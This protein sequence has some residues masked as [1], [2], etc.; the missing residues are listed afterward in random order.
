MQPSE[1]AELREIVISSCR[2]VLPRCGLPIGAEPTDMVAV[3]R[4][5][6]RAVEQEGELLLF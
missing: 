6:A 4:V 2:H 5:D 1:R 3:D